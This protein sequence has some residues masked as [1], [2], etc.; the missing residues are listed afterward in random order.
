MTNSQ[1]RTHEEIRSCLSPLPSRLDS[2]EIEPILDI[3]TG[4]TTIAVAEAE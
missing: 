2:V 3:E 4:T 1:Q